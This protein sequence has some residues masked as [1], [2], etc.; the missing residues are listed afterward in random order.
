M[1]LRYKLYVIGFEKMALGAKPFFNIHYPSDAEFNFGLLAAQAFQ[2]KRTFIASIM[3]W[4]HWGNG[5]FRT[6]L[7]RLCTPTLKISVAPNLPRVS[8][9]FKA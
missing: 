9:M 1:V 7:V 4:Q 6:A 3:K 5:Q 8:S 2:V